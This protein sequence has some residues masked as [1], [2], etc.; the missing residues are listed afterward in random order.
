M[1]IAVIFPQGGPGG[2][3]NPKFSVGGGACNDSCAL[4][5]STSGEG[6]AYFKLKKDLNPPMAIEIL[7]V[8]FKDTTKRRAYYNSMLNFLNIINFHIMYY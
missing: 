6:R 2:G 8:L 1:C 4:P 7:A 5:A 3:Q